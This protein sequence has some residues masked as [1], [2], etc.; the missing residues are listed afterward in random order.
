MNSSWSVFH[1]S[2]G[3]GGNLEYHVRVGPSRA[4][5]NDLA[6]VALSPQMMGLR[7]DNS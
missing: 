4:T 3:N 6:M 1:E 2:I 5:M 7:P